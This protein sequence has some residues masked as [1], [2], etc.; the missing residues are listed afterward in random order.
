MGNLA[1]SILSIEYFFITSESLLPEDRAKIDPYPIEHMLASELTFYL[2]LFDSNRHSKLNLCSSRS[3][4][5]L[6]Q[7]VVRAFMRSSI[8]SDVMTVFPISLLLCRHTLTICKSTFLRGTCTSRMMSCFYDNGSAK[9]L[10]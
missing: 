2:D 6:F 8:L 1:T 4:V 7:Y 10:N 3:T 9:Q 5:A